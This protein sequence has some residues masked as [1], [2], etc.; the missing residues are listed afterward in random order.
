M[1]LIQLAY[2][3]IKAKAL[4]SAL[5]IL[6]FG[7]GVAIIVL[8][9]LVSTHLQKEIEKNAQGIDLVVGAKGSPMQLILANIFHV[10]FPTGNIGLKESAQLTRNR[11]I[12]KSI[13]IISGGFLPRIQNSR[14]HASISGTIQGRVR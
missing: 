12:K 11:L 8:I 14:D 10:D 7:F 9:L 3:N 4:S 2:R 5:S 1:T 13:P 6:L